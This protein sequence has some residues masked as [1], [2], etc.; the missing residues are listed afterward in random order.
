M[1]KDF[2]SNTEKNNYV[3]SYLEKHLAQY[4]GVNYVYAVINKANADNIMIISD[5]PDH[6]VANYL[7]RKTQNIDPVIINALS[8]VTSFSWDENLKISSQ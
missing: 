1:S 5:S 7:S 8:R 2:Y 6:L 4:G 3:K